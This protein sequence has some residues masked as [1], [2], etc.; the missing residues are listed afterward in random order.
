MSCDEG[1]THLKGFI[2]PQHRAGSHVAD[3]VQVPGDQVGLVEP[4]A[5]D[6]VRLVPH[7]GQQG[8]V[9]CRATGAG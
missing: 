4:A 6:V 1:D 5:E 7:A 8:V 3:P 2:E 9:V